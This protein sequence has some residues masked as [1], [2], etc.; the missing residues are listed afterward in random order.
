MREVVLLRYYAEMSIAEAAETLGVP[1]KTVKSRLFNALAR[2]KDM[3][4]EDFR[5]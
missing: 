3:L 5:P 2:L 1:T 4:P